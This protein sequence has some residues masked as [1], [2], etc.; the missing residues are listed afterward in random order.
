MLVFVYIFKGCINNKEDIVVEIIV[1]KKI[2][3][4][5]L[6]LVFIV[7]SEVWGFMLIK[8][9]RRIY[10][11]IIYNIWINVWFVFVFYLNF[12]LLFIDESFIGLFY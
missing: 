5:M 8:I 10:L 7:F 6:L 2:M 9:C 11:I 12:C 3:L 4:I 1:N